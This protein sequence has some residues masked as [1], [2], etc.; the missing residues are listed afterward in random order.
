M[1]YPRGCIA[2]KSCDYAVSI[3]S[4]NVRD[5][6][7]FHIIGNKSAGYVAI[8]LS[9]DRVMVNGFLNIIMQLL[10]GSVDKRLNLR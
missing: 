1:G 4:D 10:V 7:S 9:E 5:I 3:A 8:G 2:K 6:Y